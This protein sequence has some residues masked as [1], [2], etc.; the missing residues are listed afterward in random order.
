MRCCRHRLSAQNLSGSG[1]TTAAN[2]LA[3][4]ADVD[5]DVNPAGTRELP[6]EDADRFGGRDVG[7]DRSPLEIEGATPANDVTVGTAGEI[8]VRQTAEGAWKLAGKRWGEPVHVA[9]GRK[10]VVM[11]WLA[12]L[13]SD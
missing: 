10:G 2:A 6:A 9:V 3:P 11:N 5:A 12:G 13:C 7:R 8:C 1:N 4:D